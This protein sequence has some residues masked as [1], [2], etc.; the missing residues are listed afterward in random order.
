MGT[1]RVRPSLDTTTPVGQLLVRQT[2]PNRNTA[3]LTRGVT[4]VA[5][6]EIS[7]AAMV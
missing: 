5:P 2:A 3:T 4:V 1:R 7:G 6:D